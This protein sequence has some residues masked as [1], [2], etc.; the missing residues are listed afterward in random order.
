MIRIPY[1]ISNYETLVGEGYIYI[2]RTN[3]I[4]LIEDRYRYIF[5]L[6]PRKF[7]KSLFLSMLDYYYN[8]KYKDRFERL[9]GQFYIGQKPT[10]MAN[11]YLILRLDFSQ[12]ETETFE[13]TY[14]GFTANVRYGAIDFYG[15]YPEYFDEEDISKVEKL[16][17][18]SE[19]IQ[20]VISKTER[21][22]PH[23]IYL[24]IDE[25]DHFANEI[26]SFRFDDFLDMVG[27]NGFVRKFYETI[28]VGTQKAVIDRLFVTGVS[29]IT[30][31][32]LTSGFNIATNIS[33][34]KD[35]NE[36][37]G[38]TEAEVIQILRGIG[39]PEAD[40]DRVLG[41]LRDWYNGYLF[42][43]KA[44]KR[45]YNSNMVLYF[46]YK[47]LYS[48][49]YP[50]EL[51]DPNIA[52]DYNK[53]RKSF[54]IKGSE[55]ENLV[56]L[57][58]LVKTGTLESEL[59]QLYDLE[60]RFDTADFIS[61]LYY[62]GIITIS[63]SRYK[64]VIFKM[65]NYVIK[66]LYFQ[67]FHQVLLEKSHLDHKGINVS[68]KIIPLADDNNMLPLLAYTEEL[69]QELSVRDK[70]NFD[71]K[72]IKLIFTSAFH[73]AE[74]YHIYNER[75]V[76]KSKTE[77]GFVDLLLTKR[78]PFE[79]KFQFVIEFKYLKK[80]DAHKAETVKQQAIQQLQAYL[81][82]DEKL[83]SLEDLKPYVIVFVGNKGEIV[84]L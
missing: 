73:I 1:G 53:I 42:S 5:F 47:Y 15:R 70:Q 29:P 27:R 76:K 23:Q 24:L 38:F 25:Y 68:N 45:V 7:G 12:I 79:P 48:R 6:R 43:V 20:D 58:K 10:K 83:Q 59:V 49:E 41:E 11:Q 17:T 13:K 2:D 33:L 69:L 81:Q 77:K 66:Q 60:K 55:K 82:H 30:L 72:Y 61:L 16:T 51:L 26:L 56:H 62:Q 21:K 52:S 75:E 71:E 74:I 63:E 36:M 65:P 37:L 80:E 35:V 22:T 78:P 34:E 9:F 14:N 3:F 39:I 44:K 32:S 67:Y 4:E 8:I 84:E 28:K 50:E 31:D 40:L 46:A 64:Q 54:K 18:P 57:D 19:I